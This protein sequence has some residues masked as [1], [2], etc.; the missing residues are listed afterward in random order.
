MRIGIFGTGNI[1]T[2]FGTLL[3][4]A[5]ND[6]DFIYG[7]TPENADELSKQ[8]GAKAIVNLNEVPN[9]SDIW[10]LAVSD[11]ALT[12]LVSSLP[13]YSG[14]VVHTAGSIPQTIFE[15]KF[16]NY[17]VLYPYQST[18]K[19]RKPNPPIPIFINGNSPKV[20]NS[21][22]ALANPWALSVTVVNDEQRLNYHL[23]AI[24][25][26]NFTNYILIQLQEF[27]RA[28]N[29]DFD[30]VMPLLQ[31]TLN[32]LNKGPA[33]TWQTGPAIRKD[34]VTI[35]KHLDLIKNEERLHEM[36]AFLTNAIKHYFKV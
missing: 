18:R 21:L 5:G 27:M 6:I 14:I 1:A 22:E 10:I 24:V 29:L 25:A 11:A 13:P 34:E 31:E 32:R 26:N 33:N 7:R 8:L 28:K 20:I 15:E 16:S 3:K 2:V 9:G 36:Y 23:A 12:P 17:G 35:Q 30:L 19:E 4:N